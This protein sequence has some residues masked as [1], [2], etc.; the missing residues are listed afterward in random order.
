MTQQ[1]GIDATRMASGADP[2]NGATSQEAA[3]KRKPG[4]PA[5]WKTHNETSVVAAACLMAGVDPIRVGYDS[6]APNPNDALVCPQNVD[7]SGDV[8]GC[9]VK[10][11]KAITDEELAA[12][13]LFH[14]QVFYIYGPYQTKQ[15]ECVPIHTWCWEQ[16]SMDIS[17]IKMDADK[18]S[19]SVRIVPDW[20]ESTVQKEHLV[21]WLK[22][23]GFNDEFFNPANIEDTPDWDVLDS[24]CPTH[25]PQLAA[26]LKAWREVNNPDSGYFWKNHRTPKTALIK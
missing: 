5:I 14:C 7:W 6:E 17:K 18:Y 2:A 11:V 24:D 8:Y 3:E 25:S 12:F 10:L 21:E 20:K 1:R 9:F 19:V 23:I 22:R 4:I 13:R 16:S 26:A 15:K